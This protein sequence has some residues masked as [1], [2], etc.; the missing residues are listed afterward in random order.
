MP[1]PF[2]CHCGKTCNNK[3]GLK[4][5]P[6]KKGCQSKEMQRHGIGSP[7]KM[8]AIASLKTNHTTEN[9][10]FEGELNFADG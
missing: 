4:I 8:R 1:A 5:C 2:V 3:C 6:S 10:L 9:V 7:G